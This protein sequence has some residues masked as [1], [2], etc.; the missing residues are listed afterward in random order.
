MEF[1]EF[2]REKCREV[3]YVAL[4]DDGGKIRLGIVLGQ[5][6]GELCAPFSA[7]FGCI[8]ET[9]S[10]Q[11]SYYLD[12]IDALRAYGEEHH[13]HVRL[14][15]P[16]EIYSRHSHI[17]KQYLAAI[18]RGA[19]LLHTDYSYARTLNPQADIEAELTHMGRSGYHV[20]C[21]AGLTYETAPTSDAAMFREA[22]AIIRANHESRGYPVRMSL[23]ELVATLAC[24]ERRVRGEV[25]IVKTADGKA[26]AAS[27][28]YIH[29]NGIVQPIYWGHL[30]E[31]AR[32]R[33]MN[34]MAVE[35]ARNYASLGLQWIDQGVSSIGGIPN[36]G[37]CMFKNSLGYELFAKP[38]IIL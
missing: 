26:A 2:N 17:E 20:A 5:K 27:I 38:T 12:S 19:K 31:T 30:D 21:R 25:F 34:F 32:L 8:E 6:D 23:E 13:S 36:Y 3:H 14:T 29:S 35:M 11:I 22:Y 1:S 15:L 24:I 10:Q 18:T 7:P 16:P 37:L 9:K 4:A 28:N 33:P